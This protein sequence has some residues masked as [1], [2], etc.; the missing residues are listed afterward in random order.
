MEQYLLDYATQLMPHRTTWPV[1]ARWVSCPCNH[2]GVLFLM[3]QQAAC[4]SKAACKTLSSSYAACGTNEP[5]QPAHAA[6]EPEVGV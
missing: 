2:G 4:L 3:L 6:A 5:Q 1:R